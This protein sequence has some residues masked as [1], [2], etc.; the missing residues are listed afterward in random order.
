M[1]SNWIISVLSFFGASLAGF[2]FLFFLFSTGA[3]ESDPVL[4][5]FGSI[6]LLVVVLFSHSREINELI[7]FEPVLLSFFLQGLILLAFGVYSSGN[8]LPTLFLFELIFSISFVTFKNTIW[9]FI[10]PMAMTATFVAISLEME[11]PW[12]ILLPT[13]IYL[14]IFYNYRTQTFAISPSLQTSLAI[15]FILLQGIGFHTKFI[16]KSQNYF[17]SFLIL[18]FLL[19]LLYFFIL[20]NSK[21]KDRILSIIC[22]LIGFVFS[23]ET[24]GILASFLIMVLAFQKKDSVILIFAIVLSFGFLGFYYYQMNVSLQMKSFFLLGT[25]VLHLLAYILYPKQE[26]SNL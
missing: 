26:E 21:I 13:T 1:K 11:L 22:V 17:T 20:E 7:Y 8:T 4:V 16:S 24:P 5:I 23:L 6:F 19:H 12:F 14:L 15:S 3:I 25:G 10:A 9:K 2:L 18:I